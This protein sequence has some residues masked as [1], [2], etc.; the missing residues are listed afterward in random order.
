MNDNVTKRVEEIQASGVF[1]R[2]KEIQSS[3][4]ESA[5]S[6]FDES[7]LGHLRCLIRLAVEFKDYLEHGSVEIARGMQQLPYVGHT[8]AEFRKDVQSASTD[9]FN[10]YDLGYVCESILSGVDSFW[11]LSTAYRRSVGATDSKADWGM[12][13][14]KEVFKIQFILMFN[15]FTEEANFKS[16][17][18]LLLDLFKLQMV[19][20]G[21]SYTD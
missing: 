2:V 10:K 13:S 11:D 17:C 15:E 8:S 9:P 18:R 14:S 16:K 21:I 20:A 19:F 1:K 4:A 5:K 6:S 12:I 3:M 7:E